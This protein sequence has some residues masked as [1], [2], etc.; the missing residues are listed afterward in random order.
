[1]F[2]YRIQPGDTLHSI[3]LRF[4]VSAYAIMAVNPGLNPY[5]LYPG[6]IILIPSARYQRY[7]SYPIPRRYP[8]P[9]PPW[10]VNPYP[11]TEPPRRTVP[12]PRSFPGPGP[13]FGDGPQWSHP[14]RY[15]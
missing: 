11:R 8:A 7:P 5:D 9:M 13:E 15:R 4:N 3:A 6:Q 12:P 1:M 14:G 2:Q 10:H